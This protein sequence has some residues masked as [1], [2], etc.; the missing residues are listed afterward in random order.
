VALRQVSSAG[1]ATLRRIPEA[2]WTVAPWFLDGEHAER[3][4]SMRYERS[5]LEC[6]GATLGKL[7]AHEFCLARFRD[8]DEAGQPEDDTDGAV[9][10]FR[11]REILAGLLHGLYEPHVPVCKVLALGVDLAT[12]EQAKPS[13]DWLKRFTTPE[14]F[15][16]AD[17]EGQVWANA[18][19]ARIAI[20]RIPEAKGKT[21]DFTLE[22]SRRRYCVEAKVVETAEHD[23]MRY[24]HWLSVH[25][26]SP[27][28]REYHVEVAPEIR[29]LGGDPVGRETYRR[30]QPGVEAALN[31]KR[32]ELEEA[33]SPFGE[34]DVPGAGRI[35]ISIR[36]PDFSGRSATTL[37]VSEASQ[38][39]K[40]RRLIKPLR[41]AAA[42]FRIWP[43]RAGRVAVAMIDAP[44]DYNPEA[45]QQALLQEVVDN[46]ADYRETDAIV[47]RRVALFPDEEGDREKTHHYYAS[48]VGC[49]PWCRAPEA[50]IAELTSHVLA[51]PRR[52]WV[53]ERRRG[54]ADP[55][56]S[57]RDRMRIFL[58]PLEC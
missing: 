31:R 35:T 33:G 26:S 3:L 53:P 17:F 55:F 52:F 30:I 24:E 4:W 8:V 22:W 56:P 16:G 21:P 54:E 41:D 34:H 9:R 32:W 50:E 23:M 25:P 2:D 45:A 7:Y 27:D 1:S 28:D 20:A 12:V 40:A 18:L 36:D 14:G 5:E 39:E 44:M 11:Q 13:S 51:S 43:G 42:K 57:V 38:W 37:F 58:T 15:R 6:A 19:R 46:R 10:K 49:L 48:F 29:A 47:W